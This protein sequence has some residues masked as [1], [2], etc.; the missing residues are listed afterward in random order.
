MFRRGTGIALYFG[1][2]RFDLHFATK[3]LAQ[4]MQTPSK[5]SMMR[6]R[7]VVRADVGPFFA[8]QG[9]PNT[10]L[11]WTDGDWRGNALTCKST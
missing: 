5:I 8:C 10:V 2:D 3:G 11:V 7:R 1:P 4:D 6:L 9:E